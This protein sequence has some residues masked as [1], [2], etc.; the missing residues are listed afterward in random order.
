[1]T[2]REKSILLAVSICHGLVHCYMLV[3]PMIYKSLGTAL[4][5]KFAGVGFVGM[6]S[7]L[8][9]GFGAL[10]TG[11]LSDKLG[12]RILLIIC[13]AGM[14]LASVV[15]FFATSEVGVVIALVLLGLFGSLYHPVGLSL[16]STS[17]KEL[18]KGLGIHGMA[19]TIG[20]ACAPIVAGVVTARLGWSYSYLALGVLGGAVVALVAR[21]LKQEPGPLVRAREHLHSMEQA[22]Y[23]ELGGRPERPE[24][25]EH[26]ARAELHARPGRPAPT[27]DPEHPGFSQPKKGLGGE[28]IILYAVG[29]FYGLTYRVLMTFFPSYLSDRVTYIGG[30]VGR[31]GWI[32]SGIL[33][34]SLVGPLLGGHLASTRR[35]I[36]RNLLVVFSM[37]AALSL[38]FYF[39]RDAALILVAVPTVL[40]LYCFQPLQNVLV[41]MSSHHTERGRVYGINYAVSFGVGALGAGM[42]GVIGERYG[43]RSIFL[44]MLGFCL[45]EIVLIA[46]SRYLRRRSHED[47]LP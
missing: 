33:V 16:L 5:L 6:A 45:V 32:S 17:I 12:A 15:A 30:N 9:F 21:T 11:F 37:L 42:G 3:F 19:G 2:S 1:M 38:G 31:L 25:P 40:L 8:A 24:H 23:L 34:I 41:A 13:I 46:A 29:M 44:L 36:E 28:L 7:Y 20:D 10:P 39:L 18:G 22:E 47:G 26:T 4:N 27:E 14:T 43:M 35:M